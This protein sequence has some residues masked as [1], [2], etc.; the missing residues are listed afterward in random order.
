[1]YILA[2][3]VLIANYKAEVI[4]HEKVNEKVY[5]SIFKCI[6]PAGMEFKAGQYINFKVGLTEGDKTRRSYSLANASGEHDLLETYVDITPGGPGSM[7]FNS[8]KPGQQ[9][10]FLGPLGRFNFAGESEKVPVFV[11]TGTGIVPF[12]GM[13]RDMAA[14]K[15]AAGATANA[16]V[17][18]SGSP[19]SCQVLLYW[20]VRSQADLYLTKELADLESKLPGFSYKLCLSKPLEG[21]GSAGEIEYTGRVSAAIE[22]DLLGPGAI[23]PG[24]TLFENCD[25]YLCGSN[26]MITTVKSQLTTSG[27]SPV[28]IYTEEFY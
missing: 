23:G 25:F 11:A 19:S 6:S 15:A 22:Q 26:A 9:V 4:S 13:L 17:S 2:H 10:E 12:L 16:S 1:L 21:W 20:G 7:F 24:G 8:L 3:I 27:Q 5:R 28:Q 14:G 18:A